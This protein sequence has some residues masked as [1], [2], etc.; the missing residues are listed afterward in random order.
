MNSGHSVITSKHELR[1][2]VTSSGLRISTVDGGMVDSIVIPLEMFSAVQVAMAQYA[3]A[4]TSLASGAT[5][6]LEE[7]AK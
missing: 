5:V 1:F 2:R 3:E 6:T 4:L 7:P